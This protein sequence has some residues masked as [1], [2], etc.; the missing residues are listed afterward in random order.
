[1]GYRWMKAQSHASLPFEEEGWQEG[2]QL[3]IIKQTCRQA[4]LCQR[5]LKPSIPACIKRQAAARNDTT[6]KS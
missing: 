5:T 3:P 6:G 4:G 2:G 1:M